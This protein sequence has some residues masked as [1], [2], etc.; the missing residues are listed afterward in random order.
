MGNNKVC[1][2]AGVG[3]GNG[4]ALA[5]R[6]AQE[7]YAVAMLARTTTTTAPLAAEL[8][9][10]RAYACDVTD[11][12]SVAAT[13]A[14][15]AAE[16]GPVTTLV[17][18]A[19]LAAWGNIADTDLAAFQASFQVSA[20]GLLLATRCVAP[21]MQAAGGG[22]I[23]VIGSP[24]SRRGAAGSVAFAAAKAAQRGL[25]ESMA[26]ELWPKQIHVALLVVDGVLDLPGARS[27]MPDKP[28]AFFIAAEAV[29]ESV[30][31]LAQQPRS[32]WSFEV[33]ARPFGATW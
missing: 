12:A 18:N 28:D 22:N 27:R 3:S 16:L 7:G 33:E 32:A 6:F 25:T 23:V 20:L 19:A 15:I 30:V 29:A 4:S 24:A 5:R 31:H 1:V 2:V 8:P 17:Y 11:S 14:A 9:R 21:S 10:A 26:R 13:F